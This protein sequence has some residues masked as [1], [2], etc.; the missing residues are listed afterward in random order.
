MELFRLQWTERGEAIADR[1][2]SCRIYPEQLQ[3]I[4]GR[5][6]SVTFA[7]LDAG[8]KNSRRH[9]GKNRL[10]SPDP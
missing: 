10:C 9:P 7:G 8:F 2:I 1:R 6:H 4:R 5:A 3:Q